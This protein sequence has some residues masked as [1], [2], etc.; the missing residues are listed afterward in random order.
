MAMFA[1][2]AYQGLFQRVIFVSFILWVLL[3]RSTGEAGQR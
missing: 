1:I 3:D 2:P